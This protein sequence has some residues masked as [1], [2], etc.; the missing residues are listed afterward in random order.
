MSVV[1]RKDG[2][3]LQTVPGKIDIVVPQTPSGTQVTSRVE[4]TAAAAEND[5]RYTCQGSND[6][7]VVSMDFQIQSQ[8][9]CG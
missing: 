6:A 5:G 3:L 7:G 1:W 2:Q 4:V 9:G 8:G